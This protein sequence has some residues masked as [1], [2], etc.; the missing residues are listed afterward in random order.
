MTYD[1][2]AATVPWPLIVSGIVGIVGIG[3]TLAAAFL[4]NRAA[5]RR[6]AAALAAAEAGRQAEREHED[7]TRFHKE[8]M[9]AYA[10]YL[11]TVKAYRDACRRCA[12]WAPPTLLSANPITQELGVL[13]AVTERGKALDAFAEAKEVVMLIASPAVRMAATNVSGSLLPLGDL[14]IDEATFDQ[15]RKVLIE[16]EVDFSAAARAELLPANPMGFT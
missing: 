10:M 3:G 11:K 12:P 5:D 7:R 16:A 2:A 14:S 9:Q 15:R 8:R 6:Q 13:A 4:T 1:P